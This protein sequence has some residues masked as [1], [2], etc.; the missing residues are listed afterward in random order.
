MNFSIDI[1]NT[2]M[3]YEG[4]SWNMKG[5]DQMNALMTLRKSNGFKQKEL[6][7]EL[8]IAVST[9]SIYESNK[10]LIPI[11]IALKLSTI[12]EVEINDI[13]LPTKFMIHE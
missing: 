13:F 11:K 3:Y 4:S 5:G 7:D 6:A 9:Y 10:S 8:G 12:F 1:H 2:W